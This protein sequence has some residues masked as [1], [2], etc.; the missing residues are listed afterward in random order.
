MHSGAADLYPVATLV[1]L[2]S[3]QRKTPVYPSQ[4][5]YMYF[6][7]FSQVPHAY[8][9]RE[10]RKEPTRYSALPQAMYSLMDVSV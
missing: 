4:V 7:E 9:I 5:E 2:G 10:K 6:P 1:F 3:L 8:P